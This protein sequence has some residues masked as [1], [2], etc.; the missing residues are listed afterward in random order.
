MD[1][2]ARQTNCGG[3]RCRATVSSTLFILSSGVGARP[4]GKYDYI[5]ELAEQLSGMGCCVHL[6]YMRNTRGRMEKVVA[7]FAAAIEDFDE[8][9]MAWHSRGGRFCCDVAR[10]SGRPIR[11]AFSA[12]GWSPGGVLDIPANIL[13]LAAW[14]QHEHKPRGSRIHLEGDTLFTDFGPVSGVL[15]RDMARYPAFVSAVI[16]A[17][18]GVEG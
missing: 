7:E 14:W 18:K 8:T 3:R 17:A 2:D 12:D 15:H 9:Y 11:G 10:K 1:H 6:N 5:G 16:A 13:T 4:G